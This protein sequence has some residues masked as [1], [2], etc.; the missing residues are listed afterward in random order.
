MNTRLVL[1][2]I[3]SLIDEVIIV[4]V[5]LWGLPNWGVHIPWWGIVLICLAF[6]MYA[7]LTFRLG[8]RI[9][10]KKPLSGFTDLIG[11]SGKTIESLDPRG[12]VKVNSELWKAKSAGG[13]IPAG[14]P[15]EVVSQDGMVL[16]VRPQEK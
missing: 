10:K 5:I 3:T 15:I 12:M 14:S 4:A 11:M 8:S 2:L 1:A 6:A 7:Y 9:L 13:A 16:V